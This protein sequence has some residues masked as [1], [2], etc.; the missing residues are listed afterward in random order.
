MRAKGDKPRIAFDDVQAGDLLRVRYSDGAAKTSM[1]PGEGGANASSACVG[2]TRVIVTRPYM[3]ALDSVWLSEK[4]YPVVHRDWDDLDI[5]LLEGEPRGVMVYANVEP[6]A[7]RKWTDEEVETLNELW[8]EPNDR[9]AAQM[10]RS[11]HSVNQKKRQ[12]RKKGYPKVK[13]KV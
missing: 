2:V 5:V 4:G 12:L 3:K 13:A 8:A 1:I 7:P 6:P 11:T 10:G 9:I